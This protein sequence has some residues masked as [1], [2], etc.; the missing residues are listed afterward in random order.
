MDELR[1]HTSKD[2]KHLRLMR[3]RKV[4]DDSSFLCMSSK[5]KVI[6]E[7]DMVA[8]SGEESRLVFKE[9]QRARV[10]EQVRRDSTARREYEDCP[11]SETETEAPNPMT[12]A[13]GIPI[14]NL[15]APAQSPVCS[16]AIRPTGGAAPLGLQG[17]GG[18]AGQTCWTRLPMDQGT[19]AA[20]AQANGVFAS[21]F[22][23]IGRA[24]SLTSNPGVT[25]Q[26][27]WHVPKPTRH[28]QPPV[29]PQQMPTLDMP[30]WNTLM[31]GSTETGSPSTPV[32]P[33]PVLAKA[34]TAT[35]T[36]ES[37]AATLSTPVLDERFVQ[38]DLMPQLLPT[39]DLEDPLAIEADGVG[40]PNNAAGA[41]D[42]SPPAKRSRNQEPPV[43]A[44]QV[45]LSPLVDA[46]AKSTA[47]IVDAIDRNSRAIRC[48][49]EAL[50]T[51]AKELKEVS[52]VLK[53]QQ[54]RPSSPAPGRKSPGPTMKSVVHKRHR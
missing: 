49:G 17:L 7:E 10:E 27:P 21:S 12:Q 31:W 18:A 42:S 46:M 1:A 39:A 25:S 6:T 24:T 29:V 8:L 3:T 15:A 54:R 36:L 28:L 20:T 51:L 14:P 33:I 32:L 44:P 48:Q 11:D 30:L 52:Q 26:S 22:P 2:D 40:R 9:K 38:E 45:D 16:V 53:A 47:A 41:V 35:V 13:V 23:T 37:T 19:G 50:T 43:A 5:P 34:P 4:K